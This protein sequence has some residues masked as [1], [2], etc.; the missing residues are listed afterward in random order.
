M[1]DLASKTRRRLSGRTAAALLCGALY[2]GGAALAAPAIQP[3]ESVARAAE[4]FVRS[5]MPP[6]QSDIVVTASRLDP[7]LRLARCGGPL[8][9]SFISPGARL[10]PQVSVAVGCRVAANWTIY[11]SVTVQSRIRVWALRTPQVQ[12]ARLRAADLA[13]ETRLVSGLAVGY[14][15]DL[16]ALARETLRHPMPAG[17]VLT[18]DD[19]LPDYMVRQGDQVTMVAAIDGVQVRAAGLALQ[20]GRYGALIR[21]QNPSSTKVVEGVV[22]ADRVVDVTP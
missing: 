1:N 15:T 14:V 3:V 8:D 17:A 12:G 4:G 18:S 20:S 22:E 16:S 10:Q 21:V 19:L 9:T 7:R 5:Q 13:A 11:V 2:L 6:G